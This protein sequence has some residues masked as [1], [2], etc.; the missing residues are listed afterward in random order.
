MVIWIADTIFLPGKDL[1]KLQDSLKKHNNKEEEESRGESTHPYPDYPVSQAAPEG[2]HETVIQMFVI[3]I[4]TVHSL[5]RVPVQTPPITISYSY[6][7]SHCYF[8]IA[9]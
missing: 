8:K 6:I 3:P 9:E 1:V 4:P 2:H 7:D 5:L